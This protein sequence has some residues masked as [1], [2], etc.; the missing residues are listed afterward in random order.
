MAFVSVAGL[1]KYYNGAGKR[2]HVLRDL[3]RDAPEALALPSGR[4]TR[5]EYN[6]DGTVSASVK[7]QELFGLAETPHQ[8]QHGTAI[9]P[10]LRRPGVRGYGRSWE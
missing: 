9:A 5:L 1:N 6:D 3:D 4:T 2:L 8:R 7:L 10:C